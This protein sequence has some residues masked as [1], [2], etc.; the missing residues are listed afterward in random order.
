MAQTLFLQGQIKSLVSKYQGKDMTDAAGD[1]ILDSLKTGIPSL[2][3]TK[4]NLLKEAC[5]WCLTQCGHGNGVSMECSLW[6]E[7]FHH[8]IKWLQGVDIE[9][10]LRAYNADDAVECGAEALSLLLIR[11]KTDFT[12]ITRAAKPSGIDYWLG[13]KNNAANSLF[14]K[15]DA[16][17]E[18][19]GILK[20]S[21]TNRTGRRIKMKLSQTKASDKSGIFPVFVSVI[22]FGQPRAE[23][24][25]KDG[26]D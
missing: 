7:I 4:A 26:S 14:T 24:V 1:L 11:E 21:V 19:S 25:R 23:L 15:Q 16:R 9:G 3:E 12:A 5:I 18:I 22:E 6:T 20:E 8:P 10:M 2:T 13:Y 17:L